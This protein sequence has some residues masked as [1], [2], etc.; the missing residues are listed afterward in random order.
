MSPLYV[1]SLLEYYKQLMLMLT[2]LPLESNVFTAIKG[3]SN[4][5]PLF[6]LQTRR[7][8]LRTVRSLQ[9]FARIS[10]ISVCY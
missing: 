5:A 6:L 3:R 8:F 10:K 9:K 1:R 2:Y 7:P 4:L